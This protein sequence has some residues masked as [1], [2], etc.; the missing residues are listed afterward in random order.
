M[1]TSSGAWPELPP[2]DV[3]LLR[4]LRR[5]SGDRDAADGGPRLLPQG[6]RRQVRA[7]T[8]S[9]TM[10]RSPTT[11]LAGNCRSARL[12]R[13]AAIWDWSKRCASSPKS[14]SGRR[15]GS[16]DRAVSGFG[17]INYDRGLATGAAVLA[18]RHDQAARAPQTQ[19]PAA[20]NAGAARPQEVRSRSAQ[21]LTAAAAE[22][23]RVPGVHRVRQ[24]V[25]PRA[26]P[27]RRAFGAAAYRDIDPA[28]TLIAEPTVRARPIVSPRAHA[29]A[30]RYRETRRGPMMV[31]H[32]HD[33]A[34][35]G[36]RVRL[37][38]KLDKSGAPWFWRC[39]NTRRPTCRTIASCAK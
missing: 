25:Y 1:S 31:P 18:G 8:P 29:V 33:D 22:G 38:L 34:L 12:A 11:R 23:R 4:D 20:Q 13:P 30:T 6:R 39:L 3:D 32:L 27:V 17:M 21:G 28:G 16:E 10:V 2:D 24:R 14:R 36:A 7:R 19:G 26:T 35:E 9:P 5:L 37:A 15:R